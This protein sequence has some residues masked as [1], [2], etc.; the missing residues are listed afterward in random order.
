MHSRHVVAQ[1]CEKSGHFIVS[2][3]VRA[4]N[5]CDVMGYPEYIHSC[6]QMQLVRWLCGHQRCAELADMLWTL[7]CECCLH[8]AAPDAA[9]MSLCRDNPVVL[10]ERHLCT[11]RHACPRFA[12]MGPMPQCATVLT[13]YLRAPY[14]TCFCWRALLYQ[15]GLLNTCSTTLTL[16]FGSEQ[17]WTAFGQMPS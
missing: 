11:L 12:A 5:Q 7:H 17:R 4:A 3:V 1:W 2:S 6:T 10:L 8:A 14:G 13:A 9:W 15:A 16:V